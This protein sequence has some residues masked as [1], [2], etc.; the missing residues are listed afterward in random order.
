MNL[1]CSFPFVLHADGQSHPPSFRLR[2]FFVFSQHILDL[3]DR[4]LQ[5]VVGFQSLH[6]PCQQAVEDLSQQCVIC[7]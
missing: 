5:L 7:R 3:L 4:Y 1:F 2:A 6:I